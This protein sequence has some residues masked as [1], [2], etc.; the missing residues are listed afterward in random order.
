[1]TAI[2]EFAKAAARPGAEDV[3]DVARCELDDRDLGRLLLHLRRLEPDW[4]PPPKERRR[5]AARLLQA[6][7]SDKDIVE[8]A[9]I[10]RTT[11]WRIRRDLVNLPDPARQAALQSG[12]NVSNRPA[13]TRRSSNFISAPRAFSA[14]HA[15]LEPRR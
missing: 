9:S 3:Y 1:V 2:Q 4:R 13:S 15:G 7:V 14:N 5:L 8:Q 6:G 12:A 11:V 10:S